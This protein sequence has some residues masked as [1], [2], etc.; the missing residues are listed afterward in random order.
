[1]LGNSDPLRDH[2]L[3]PSGALFIDGTIKAFRR[4]GFPR[5]W[6]N[7]VCSDEETINTVD[8]KWGSYD[9]GEPITSPSVK[10]RKMIRKGKDEITVDNS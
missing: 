8:S 9:L 5:K 6:P 2:K 4:G 3:L 10:Y 7:I 1:L